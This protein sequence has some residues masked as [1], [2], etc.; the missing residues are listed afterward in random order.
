VTLGVGTGKSSK[1][2]RS[3]EHKKTLSTPFGHQ[4]CGR[5]LQKKKEKKAG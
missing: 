3:V 1:T 2:L 4:L 5:L